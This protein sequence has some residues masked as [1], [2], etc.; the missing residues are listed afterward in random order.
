MKNGT[1]RRIMLALAAPFAAVVFATIASSIFLLIAGSNPFTTYGDMF[2]YGS[3]LEIQVD[4]LN[5]ATPLYISGVAAAI[6]FRM[7]LFNIGV[8][9]QY[10][11]AAIVAAYVGASVSLPGVLHVGLI[12]I[13]AMLV[14]GA[15]SGVAGVLKV[16]R[17]VNEVISTIMLNAI[18]ISGLIA[19]LVR[20]WQ[21]GGSV[22]ATAT[23]VG[24]GTEPI[25][26]SGLI[27]NINSWLE[28]FTRDIEKG[29][30]LTGI[31]LVAIAVGILYH[32]LINR[33][34][35]G[36]DLRATGINP[37]SARVGGVS[38]KKMVLG[39]MVL[40]GVVAGLVG[41]AEIA[42]LGRFNPNFVGGL[43]FAG[44]AVALLGRNHPG[45]IAIGA[46]LFA[47]LDTAS[48]VLQVT[49]SASREIV[50]IMQGIILLAAVIAYE[51]VQRFRIREEARLASALLE[52]EAQ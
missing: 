52:G 8:E 10:R 17:G 48:G 12:L 34:R 26:E 1:I 7:N 41:M 27:P 2:E 50:F 6:G 36:F 42:K 13:V 38:D 32:I 21:A 37:F 24:I 46:L 49:G 33:T 35:F 9:G 39:A 4:I 18:A 30:E 3:R 23:N 16:T 43:G 40:S 51:V 14:G 29:K 22:D 45:G 47:F 44:I 31:F 25:D 5:R 20:E 28:I 11:L 15:Y 19:W